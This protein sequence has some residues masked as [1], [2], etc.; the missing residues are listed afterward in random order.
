MALNDIISRI[1]QDAEKQAAQILAAAEAQAKERIA[2]CK[3]DLKGRAKVSAEKREAQIDQH[4]VQQLQIQ[5]FISDQKVLSYKREA[6]TKVIAQTRQTVLADEALRAQVYT[7]TLRQLSQ[8]VERIVVAAAEVPLVQKVCAS[9]A[10]NCPV[11]GAAVEIGSCMAYHGKALLNC[12]LDIVI[13]EIA[14]ANEGLIAQELFS[15]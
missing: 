8:G 4:N 5:K 12:S 10:L 9:L 2:Q 3:H 14:Q 1:N 11:E 15:A 7:H 13:N 6:L